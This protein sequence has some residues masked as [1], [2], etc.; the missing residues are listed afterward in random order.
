MT[1]CCELV[2]DSKR[3]QGKGKDAHNLAKGWLSPDRSTL[4]RQV[5]LDWASRRHQ[6]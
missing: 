3:V 2:E 4:A 1:C 5:D 6:R